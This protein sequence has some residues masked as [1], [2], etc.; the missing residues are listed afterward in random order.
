MVGM[1]NQ[2]KADA[3]VLITD[4]GDSKSPLFLKTNIEEAQTEAWLYSICIGQRTRDYPGDEPSWN[5][6]AT[7]Q[8]PLQ[9]ILAQI[10]ED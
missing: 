6:R 10:A 7:R 8:M 2:C 3:S 4:G 1:A 9:T 5:L